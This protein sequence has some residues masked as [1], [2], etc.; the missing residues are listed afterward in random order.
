MLKC[1]FICI[2]YEYRYTLLSTTPSEPHKIC[3]ALLLSKPGGH[4]PTLSVPFLVEY[5]KY[6]LHLNL[7]VPPEQLVLIFFSPFL[8]ATSISQAKHG[9]V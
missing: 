1:F 8:W 2:F 3:M 4:S 7:V 9:S 6:C 5:L